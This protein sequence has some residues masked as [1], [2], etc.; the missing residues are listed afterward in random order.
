MATTLPDLFRGD[1]RAM[2]VGGTVIGHL[3]LTF[4]NLKDELR[5]TNTVKIANDNLA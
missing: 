2:N 5:I 1:L 4:E 3:A